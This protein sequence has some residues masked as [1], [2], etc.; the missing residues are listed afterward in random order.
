[1]PLRAINAT[2]D[3]CR[4]RSTTSGRCLFLRVRSQ[5]SKVSS[6]NRTPRLLQE[7]HDADEADVSQYVHKHRAD[8]DS[9]TSTV[10]IR[11]M[12]SGPRIGLSVF[13]RPLYVNDHSA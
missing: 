12:L 3:S 5:K 8:P 10:G 4:T 7:H 6:Q 13:G 1:M 2:S 9:W 11:F